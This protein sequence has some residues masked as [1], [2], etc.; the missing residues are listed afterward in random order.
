MLEEFYQ[1]LYHDFFFKWIVLNTKIY[2]DDH[3]HC[4]VD[5]DDKSC[6]VVTFD[7]DTVCGYVTIWTNN[8]VEEKIIQKNNQSILFYLH[9]NVT[10]LAQCRLLFQEFYRILLSH[11]NHQTY[12]IALCC[13]DGLSTAMFVDEMKEV[14][15]LEN[16]DF[17]VDSLSLDELCHTYQDYNAIYLAPQIAFKQTD[18]LMSMKNIPIH[19]IDP[20]D[21]ATKNYQGILKII[22]QNILTD[23]KC[24]H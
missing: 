9:Y 18:F 23:K 16:L 24:Y 12:K 3:I 20:T 2:C 11:N 15:E 17:I 10:D 6:K 7:M 22:Q 14:I 1:T 5:E 13:N 21:F 4:H 19:R 8:I